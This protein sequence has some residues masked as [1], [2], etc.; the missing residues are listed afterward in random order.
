MRRDEFN[1]V[2]INND[3]QLRGV[4]FGKT[5]SNEIFSQR[6]NTVNNSE[7][8]ATQAKD[9]LNEGVSDNRQGAHHDDLTQEELRKQFKENSSN[10]AESSSSGSSG[11]ESTTGASSSAGSAGASSVGASSSGAAAASS[12]AA[13][14]AGTAAVSASAVVIT[15]F[16]VIT[17]AP[18][19]I[20]Q[21]T[22][23]LLNFEVGEHELFYEVELNDVI[24]NGEYKVILSN[25]TYNE[26][27]PLEAGMNHGEFF[28]LEPNTEY[29]FEVEEGSEVEI[30][31]SLLKK[32]FTTEEGYIGYSE[33]I[34]FDFDKTANFLDGTFTVQLNYIDELDIYSDFAFTL[35]DVDNSSITNRFSLEKTTEPQ[36][37]NLSSSTVTFDL[38]NE[39]SYKLTYKERDMEVIFKEETFSFTDTSGASSIFYGGGVNTAANFLDNTFTAYI[40]FVDGFNIFSDFA[41]H[42]Y[43]IDSGINNE[44]I[45]P[46]QS[47]INA[48][49][50]SANAE[51]D[52]PALYLE[53]GVFKY[54]FTY[55]RKGVSQ[56]TEE[57]EVSFTDIYGRKTEAATVVILENADFLAGTFKAQ[58][59][60]VDDYGWLDDFVLHISNESTSYS[61]DYVLS[62]NTEEQT[63]SAA[64]DENNSELDLE[65]S[66]SYYLTYTRNGTSMSTTPHNVTFV[67]GEDRKAEFANISVNDKA[68]FLDKTFDVQLD[69]TDDYGWLD[70]FILHISKISSRAT[71]SSITI[72][73]DYPL[74]KSKEVQTL[75]TDEDDENPEFDLE[76]AEC[77]YY[78]TYTRRG[79][80]MTTDSNDITFEDKNERKAEF[81]SL[82]VSDKAD[83]LEGTFNIQLNYT[84]DYDW[85]DDFVLH[86]SNSSSSISR[87]YELSKSLE[88]QS[89]STSASGSDPELDIEDGEYTYYLSYTR[90]GQS[91]S[92]DSKNITFTDK[93]NRKTEFV[94]ASIDNKADFLERT[95]KVQLDYTDDYGRLS[96]FVFH[97]TENDSL[98]DI[99][100]S[101]E[102][103]LI[104]T[105]DEQVLSADEDE[106]NS[107]F[108]LESGTYSC[109][110]SYE[111][112]G[113]TLSTTPEVVTFEDV[114]SRRSIYNDITI[115]E[116]SFED[117]TFDVKLDFE[118][119]LNRLDGWHIILTDTVNS[120]SV[121]YDLSETTDVQTFSAYNADADKTIDLEHSTLTYT[122]TYN[123]S[124]VEQVVSDDTTFTDK[125]ELVSS[126]NAPIFDDN[127]GGVAYYNFYTGELDITL[128]YDDYFDYFSNF[129]IVFN[130]DF[131]IEL[132]KQKTAQT[133]DGGAGLEY[134]VDFTTGD[135]VNYELFYRTK[136]DPDTPVSAATGTVTFVDNNIL[137]INV[138]RIQYGDGSY[139][140]PYQIEFKED[141]SELEDI[142][143]YIESDAFGG[144]NYLVQLT[145]SGNINPDS[146]WQCAY[147]SY[148][149][150]PEVVFDDSES[151]VPGVL[152]SVSGKIIAKT[153]GGARL[154]SKDI[155]LTYNDS[156]EHML[157]R[158]IRLSATDW[159]EADGMATINFFYVV[160]ENDYLGQSFV[161][162]FVDSEN[163]IFDIDAT[164]PSGYA[165]SGTTSFSLEDYSTFV[166]EAKAGNA[167]AVYI[168]YLDSEENEVVVPCYTSFSF[169]IV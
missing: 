103:P 122:L 17:A 44:R 156:T 35:T 29:D 157:L 74:S 22:A 25:E 84:D 21:A 126:V 117:K 113:E 66:Y 43:D 63:L 39:Y 90:K 100:F 102:Y 23:Q 91:M 111:L 10:G 16:T 7:L 32:T 120:V 11:A 41:L 105:L 51:M 139:T 162:R 169:E 98:A 5:N 106:D 89:L 59:S 146:K 53:T 62:K 151:D 12:S 135:P 96:N 80:L 8:N 112:K 144:E 49:T 75:S 72:N 45:Y 78:L 57:Q 145:Y 115:N 19:I 18:I 152:T 46:L 79:E 13:A 73:R 47:N 141:R 71:S 26:S 167:F 14:T 15:A 136:A 87:D 121:S 38:E 83:F 132:N 85:L 159:A 158:G 31:R 67:D 154:F 114:D 48:Q 142:S 124:G 153:S 58:L 37:I 61:R 77:T 28:N 118:D 137:D 165:Y 50:L 1:N 155:S 138:G 143:V 149:S 166:S 92:T 109:Y 107:G 134:G 9:E 168:I 30:K 147:F 54:Y 164:V 68:D 125:E 86:V 163:N 133:V 24:E 129:S 34:N 3:R 130:S 69:F 65:N 52:V 95:F 93:D 160:G 116:A 128:D 150:E 99:P 131:E 97:I 20:S 101:R 6:E 42:I 108:D 70:N 27:K 88:I 64:E 123:E 33:F 104:K 127:G 60:Y 81:T 94:S 161:I 2:N 110:F 56:Q 40:D 55:K 76:D 119:G 36:T 4:E 140:V 82:T 148:G